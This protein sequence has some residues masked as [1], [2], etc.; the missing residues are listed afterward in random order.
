MKS[1]R[2][3]SVDVFRG[4]TIALMILVNTPGTWSAVYPPLLHASWD[5][6]TPTDLV[7][8]FFLFIVGASIVLAYQSKK[9]DA[10]TLKKVFFRSLKI[11]GL[12]LFLAAFL[13]YPPFIKDFETLRIPGVLQRIGVVFFFSVLAFLFL[14]IKRIWIVFF[15]LLSSWYVWMRYIP[16]PNGNLP[17]T[18]RSIDNWSNYVD[19]HLLGQHMWQPDYDPEGLLSTL[20]ALATC[21]M[22]ILVGNMLLKKQYKKMAMTAFLA[23]VAGYLWHLDFP[24]NKANWTSSFVLVTGGYATLLLLILHYLFDLKNQTI[25]SSFKYFG[26]NPIVLYFLSSFIAKCFYM[27]KLPVENKPGIHSYLYQ[28]IFVQ[29]FLSDK[30]SSMLYAL[31]VVLFYY[32]LGYFLYK[33]K[34]FIKV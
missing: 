12:G 7:F 8:P 26:M 18:Q 24:I 15:A 16:L 34:I 10:Q 30:L 14:N 31:C 29:P 25:G 17:T 11:I 6:L 20:G 9:P 13:T 2:L 32:A 21:L 1:Q 22:G 5:G 4:I 27:I 33:K 3:L 23:L 28:N 19:F